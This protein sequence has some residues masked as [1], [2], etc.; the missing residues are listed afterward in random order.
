MPQGKRNKKEGIP[1]G[2]IRM[3]R[4][5]ETVKK[6]STSSG[7]KKPKEKNDTYLQKLKAMSQ[8]IVE[9]MFLASES[10]MGECV[11]GKIKNRIQ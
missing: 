3:V 7:A 5:L 10:R 4:S 2:T 11:D 9:Q 8:M 1:K 6:K